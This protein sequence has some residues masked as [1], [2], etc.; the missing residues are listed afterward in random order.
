MYVS[1]T[2]AFWQLF[3]LLNTKFPF[4]QENH[5]HAVMNDVTLNSLVCDCWMLHFLV[6]HL[7]IYLFMLKFTMVQLYLRG[8]VILAFLRE[9]VLNSV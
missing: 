9:L 1:I 4:S 3:Q 8:R 7:M 5:S 2:F 6:G